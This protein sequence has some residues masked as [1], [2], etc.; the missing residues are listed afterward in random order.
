MIVKMEF[1]PVYT[2]MV[3]CDILHINNG[4]DEK[5]NDMFEL[6]MYKNDR[7]VENPK[8]KDK[9]RVFVMENGKTVDR[10]DFKTESV[11]EENGC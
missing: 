5:G 6:A 1:S 4:K 10:Y 9:V 2:R 8:F 3:D 7:L 11:F